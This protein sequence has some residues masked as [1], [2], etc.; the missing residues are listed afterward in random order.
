MVGLLLRFVYVS[1]GVDHRALYPFARVVVEE[2]DPIMLAFRAIQRRPSLAV[3][4]RVIVTD[5]RAA[6]RI[7]VHLRQYR[8]VRLERTGRRVRRRHD[9][10]VRRLR[11]SVREKNEVVSKIGASLR[12]H[13][14]YRQHLHSSVVPSAPLSR[15][16]LAKGTVR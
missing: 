16:T 7:V 14:W 15:R 4:W 11:V 2:Q 5:Y 9:Q 8:R 1:P 6:V 10:R 3:L 12:G 13:V